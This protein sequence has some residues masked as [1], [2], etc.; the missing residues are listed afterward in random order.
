[1]QPLKAT[2][3]QLNY[4]FICPTKLWYFCHHLGME[5]NSDLVAAG[6]FIN[7]S[8]YERR[9]KDELIEGKICLD[10]IKTKGGKIEIHEIKKSSKMEKAHEM[11]TK[12][13]LYFLKKRGVEAKAILD[14]PLLRQRKEVEL[15]QQ[16]EIE[17]ELSLE[18][19]EKIKS[20]PNLPEPE[21][22]P[23]C[24]KCAYRDLCWCD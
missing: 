5:H 15:A 2:G 1:M 17:L 12:Y 19:I 21:R 4:L 6:R 14:Y 3:T 11:Q 13:Y 18:K 20:S 24:Q 23:I 10:Y 9:K 16:D 22:K 8:T 7:E